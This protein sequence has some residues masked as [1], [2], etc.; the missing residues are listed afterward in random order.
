MPVQLLTFRQLRKADL[1][2]IL[3]GNERCDLRKR[4]MHDRVITATNEYRVPD[5]HD[6]AC[7]NALPA[8]LPTRCV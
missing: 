4:E 7:V 6:L 5:R 2:A 8:G 1:F 3:D